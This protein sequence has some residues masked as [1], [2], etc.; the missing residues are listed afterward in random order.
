[1][2]SSMV[3]TLTIT[4]G[5]ATIFGK[6]EAT[7]A[8]FQMLASRCGGGTAKRP[9]RAM[10]RGPTAMATAPPRI[11]RPEA[12]KTFTLAAE[13][14]VCT[15]RQG[16]RYVA[17][18]WLRLLSALGGNSGLPVGYLAASTPTPAT[19]NSCSTADADARINVPSGGGAIV[20]RDSDCLWYY[21]ADTQMIEE[22]AED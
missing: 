1:M 20:E 5:M 7:L 3:R 14:T 16:M 6:A 17:L 21:C 10:K 11:S 2:Y 4:S 13:P 12:R 9:H 15:M 8:T 18:T 19:L 22:A